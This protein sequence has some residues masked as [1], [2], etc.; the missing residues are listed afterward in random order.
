MVGVDVV[1]SGSVD[2]G[3]DDGGVPTDVVEPI[4]VLVV[5]VGAS[6]ES[7]VHPTP[8]N[9]STIAIHNTPS[10]ERAAELPHVMAVR[11]PP[12]PNGSENHREA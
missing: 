6:S 10:G 5:D 7:D 4:V 1:V 2:P 12:P 9:P 11:R 8:I 3:I